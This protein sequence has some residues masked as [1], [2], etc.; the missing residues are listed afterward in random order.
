MGL[1]R[2]RAAGASRSVSHGAITA[3]WHRVPMLQPATAT[4]PVSTPSLLPLERRF[5][6]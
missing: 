3:L 6:S 5:W 1:Q 4:A 2:G